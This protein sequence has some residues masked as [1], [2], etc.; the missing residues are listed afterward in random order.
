MADPF[1]TITTSDLGLMAYLLA[2]VLAGTAL[3][4]AVAKLRMWVAGAA[5]IVLLA[6][7]F[8]PMFAPFMLAVALTVNLVAAYA[9]SRYEESF[10]IETEDFNMEGIDD[11]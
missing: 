10:K 4:V 11:E 7:A 3:I 2:L 9:P 8:L 5:A 6:T 1:I